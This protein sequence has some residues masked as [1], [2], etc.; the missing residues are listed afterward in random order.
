[1]KSK[2]ARIGILV[3][4]LVSLS[5][6][7]FANKQLDYY[8]KTLGFETAT[9]TNC[10]VFYGEFIN[11]G[12]EVIEKVDTISFVINVQTQKGWF[13]LTPTFHNLPMHL[14]PGERTI[15]GFNLWHPQIDRYTDQIIRWNY[16]Y[17]SDY[18]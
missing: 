7:C 17:H 4:L 10:L 8:G 1:M 9:G 2:L 6:P 14:R 3:I 16:Q 11:S 12:S 15:Q 18:E 13:Q 5:V